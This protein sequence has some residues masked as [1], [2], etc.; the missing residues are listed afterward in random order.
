MTHLTIDDVA[1]ELGRSR[2]WM[3]RNWPTLVAK[4][5]MPK[6]IG[7]HPLVW[8][9]AQIYAWIDRQLDPNMKAASAAM[10]AAI[11]SYDRSLKAGNRA[12]IL[13]V[14]ERRAALDAKWGGGA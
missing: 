11:S 7:K 8:N 2:D 9:D 4:D 14:A 12:G 6:P 3:Y 1:N 5:Q 13:D 10:R